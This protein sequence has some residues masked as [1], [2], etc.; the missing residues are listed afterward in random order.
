MEFI[1]LGNVLYAS[2]AA[3]LIGTAGATAYGICGRSSQLFGPSVYRGP[4]R[5]RSIAL[6]FDDGPSEGSIRLLEYLAEQGIKATFFQCGM[7]I[8][9]HPDIT[10]GIHAQGH[11]IGNH[12]YS[13]PRLCPRLSWNLNLKSPKFIADQF[14]STQ[15][16]IEA[17]VGIRPHLLRAPYGLRWYGIGA[18][19]AKLHLLGIMW[20]VIGHDWEWPACRVADLVL[21]KA[22]PGG[23]IC[24]HDG[25]DIQPNPDVSEM[26]TAVKMI[27]PELKN[28]GYRFETVSNLLRPDSMVRAV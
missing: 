12:T 15:A 9:R 25:R 2:A 28:Q 19:Q 4:G 10:R 1:K 18:A 5:R 8:R 14:S 16:I 23:I 7:N 11:E 17:E 6:T 3:T 13:H 22:S 21:A 26:L 27:V 24:L 20:T